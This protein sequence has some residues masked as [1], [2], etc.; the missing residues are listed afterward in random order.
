MDCEILQL[1]KSPYILKFDWSQWVTAL[2]VPYLKS[3]SSDDG[4]QLERPR[5]WLFKNMQLA[6]I[7]AASLK[8]NPR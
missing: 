2:E 5:R 7:I 3:R 1:E 6:S 8:S 4:K